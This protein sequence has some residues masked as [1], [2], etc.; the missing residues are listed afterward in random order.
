MSEKKGAKKIARRELLKSGAA[1]A[2]AAAGL[3]AAAPAVAAGKG[4]I[5][6]AND[7]LL[8]GVIGPGRMGRA[9]MTAL[10]GNEGVEI[11]ALCDCYKTNMDLALKALQD[12]GKP[13]PKTFSDFRK[14]LD[15]KEID[16]VI[17]AAPDHWHP[18]Q[19]VM[20]CRAGKD[21]YVE[22]P[23]SVTVSE[24]RKMVE[25]ARET[26]R[27]VG[28][29]TQQRSGKHFQRAV[30]IVQDGRL[31]RIT[32]VKT[33]NY[34]NEY[35]EGIGNP[36]DSNPPK[37]L[38]WDMW[39]GPAPMRPYNVNRF[40]PPVEGRWS[41]FR[42]FF[43][44][45]GAWITDWGT[46]LIDIVN[47]AMKVNGPE[48]ISA[49]GGKFALLDNRDTPDTLV[50]TFRYP[51]FVLTYESR[52]AASYSSS[53]HDYGIE[54]HGTEATLYVNREGYSLN[55]EMLD[56]GEES[57]ASTMPVSSGGSD[58]HGTHVKAYLECVRSRKRFISDI[59]DGHYASSTPHL[60][61]LA[62]R[63]GRGLHWDVKAERFIDDPEANK[64]LSRPY[65]APWTL[66]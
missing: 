28:V 55:P 43:D 48:Y 13:Q 38:D 50:A 45:A 21:V 47:W 52:V 8:V 12:N 66:A 3:S 11:A 4:K 7:K 29:G 39:L 15:L 49:S 44:Y 6:G 37:D 59:E 24:G 41:S 56:K 19:A 60:G 35:P 20:A 32:R 57:I 30:K 65:R 33:W 51:D 1:L 14:L 36:P 64:M 46:H 25:V 34:V 42:W 63:L 5:L 16:I 9:N 54:F 17:V 18:L 53:G 58:Q 62:Y 40:G 10:A 31:G 22:K 61:N 23:V 26:K 2:V 27:I